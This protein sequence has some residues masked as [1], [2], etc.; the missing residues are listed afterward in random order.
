MSQ[1]LSQAEVD[2]L[3]NDIS[4]RSDDDFEMPEMDLEE[5]LLDYAYQYKRTLE[6]FEIAKKNLLDAAARGIK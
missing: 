6:D 3:L 5:H 4:G 1:V 2:S